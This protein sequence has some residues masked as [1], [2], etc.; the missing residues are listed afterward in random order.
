MWLLPALGSIGGGWWYNQCGLI[1]PTGTNPVW[2]SDGDSTYHP[3]GQCHMMVK[4]Q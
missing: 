2:F 3:I 1:S 4:P